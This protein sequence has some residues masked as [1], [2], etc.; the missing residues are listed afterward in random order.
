MYVLL[1]AKQ[2]KCLDIIKSDGTSGLIR[3][4]KLDDSFD[5]PIRTN[6]YS[7]LHTDISRKQIAELYETNGWKVRKC[8][9]VDYEISCAWAE[10][11]IE[12]ENPILMHG[13]VA[14]VATR[15]EELI[16]PLRSKGIQFSC[17]CYGPEPDRE[18]LL[19][20]RS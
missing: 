10:L 12:A 20:I 9:W 17:E 19:E 1:F 15:V 3:W 5:D 4:C 6:F 2:T 11:V 13:I 8:S 14:D 18:L 7:S 16:A